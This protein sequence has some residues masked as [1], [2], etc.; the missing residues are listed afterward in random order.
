[1]VEELRPEVGRDYARIGHSEADWNKAVDD[2]RSMIADR[3]WQQANIDGLCRAF[4][5]DDEARIKYFGEID[6]RLV[7]GGAIESAS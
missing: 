1:M 7:K 2:L 6:G 4:G 5:L 3:N